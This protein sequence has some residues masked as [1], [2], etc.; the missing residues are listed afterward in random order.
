MLFRKKLRYCAENVSL[1]F[2]TMSTV[3]PSGAVVSVAARMTHEFESFSFTVAELKLCDCVA[4]P[5]DEIV[6]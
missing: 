3:S 6:N 1:Y 5:V 2:C 4:S